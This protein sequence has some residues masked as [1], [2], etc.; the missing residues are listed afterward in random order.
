[1]S[2]SDP[3]SIAANATANPNLQNQPTIPI[4]GGSGDDGTNG[5]SNDSADEQHAP[6]RE[7]EESEWRIIHRLVQKTDPLT[8]CILQI[9]S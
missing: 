3:P 7:P 8:I 4:N 6:D 5:G 2:P 9:A 1:M